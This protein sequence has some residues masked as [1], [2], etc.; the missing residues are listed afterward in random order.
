[1]TSLGIG[2]IASITHICKRPTIVQVNLLNSFPS[3]LAIEWLPDY[4]IQLQDPKKWLQDWCSVK[5]SLWA[6][7]E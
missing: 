7:Y 5:A 1:M 2:D 4:W 3:P 6:S